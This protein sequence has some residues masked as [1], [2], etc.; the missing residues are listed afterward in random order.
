M[1]SINNTYRFFALFMA[2]MMFVTS[3]GYAVDMHYCK[4]ELKSFNFFGKAKSCHEV[5]SMKNCPFHQEMSEQHTES[6][7]EKKGCC[8]NKTHW[9]QSDQDQQ[10]QTSGFVLK[11]HLQ[12]FI[13]AYVHVF[14]LDNVIQKKSL[15]FAL[16][17]P[18]LIQRDVPVL[19]QSFLL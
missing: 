9:V 18:P 4:G 2:F 5:T 15:S 16:Y 14:F 6:S 12:Q 10:V 17:K 11:N 1:K 7:M 19:F 13:I 3:V 8:E